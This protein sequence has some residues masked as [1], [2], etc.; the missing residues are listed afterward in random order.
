M[1]AESVRTIA[2]RPP[3][4]H[5]EHQLLEGM[6]GF[7]P[8]VTNRTAV[9]ALLKARELHAGY[10][11]TPPKDVTDGFKVVIDGAAADEMA[12]IL[13]NDSPFQTV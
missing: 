11:G 13:G 2:D 3:A 5:A 8:Q 9:A 12:A 4:L 1:V 10:S 6:R 7:Y